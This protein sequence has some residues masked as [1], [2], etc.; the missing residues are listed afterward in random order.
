MPFYLREGHV[1]R[2]LAVTS[3]AFLSHFIVG[4]MIHGYRHL[5]GH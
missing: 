1:Y 3:N 4:S 5:S 2:H